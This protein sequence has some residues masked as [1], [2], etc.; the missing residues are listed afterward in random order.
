[1]FQR[2]LGSANCLNAFEFIA[3]LLYLKSFFSLQAEVW[4][5]DEKRLQN[6]FNA[7]HQTI[8]LFWQKSYVETRI[9]CNV[10][11]FSFIQV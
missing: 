7:K 8:C 11:V 1:M 5:Q 10:N 6:I 4:V 9:G 3:A 2:K